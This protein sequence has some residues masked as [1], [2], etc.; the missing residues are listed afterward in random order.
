MKEPN[1]V[2]FQCGSKS[3][4]NPIN[5]TMLHEIKKEMRGKMSSDICQNITRFLIQERREREEE[6][7][8]SGVTSCKSFKYVKKKNNQNHWCSRENL[9]TDTK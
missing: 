6:E 9:K 1:V 3:W 5:K 4:G 7:R 8:K 2:S